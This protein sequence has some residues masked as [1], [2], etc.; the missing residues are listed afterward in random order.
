MFLVLVLVLVNV[1]LARLAWTAR[2]LDRDGVD[3]VAEV[4]DARA[5]GSEDDPEW[6]LAF[7]LPDEVEKREVRWPARVDEQTWRQASESGEI[8]VR[9]LPEDPRAH[10]VAGEVSPRLGLWLTLG[11]DLL[12]L[13][14]VGLLLRHRARVLEEDAAEE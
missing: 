1:P 5:L 9:V 7:E 14:L 6:W 4:V 13:G 8:A 10:T 3:V 12:L 11:V 2:E